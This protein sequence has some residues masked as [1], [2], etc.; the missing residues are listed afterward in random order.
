MFPFYIFII[1][2]ILVVI[3]AFSNAFAEAHPEQM[4]ADLREGKRIYSVSCILCHG[5]KGK[6]DGPASIFIGPYSHPRPNDFT[7]GSFKYRTTDSGDL[8]TLSDLKRTIRYG[9]PGYMPSF[10][11]LEEDG[12]RQVALYV[13]NTFIED[14]LLLEEFPELV[15]MLDPGAGENDSEINNMTQSIS[16][17]LDEEIKV[18]KTDIYEEIDSR[19]SGTEQA[20]SLTDHEVIAMLNSLSEGETRATHLSYRSTDI[21]KINKNLVSLLKRI[22]SSVTANA[23]Q[24]SIFKQ[25]KSRPSQTRPSLKASISR[26]KGIFQEM[27]CTACHGLN[28]KGAKTNMKDERGLP[29]MAADLSQP[30]SF[31]NGN[32]REDI[33][34]TVMTGLNGTPMPSFIDLFIGQVDSAWD[35]IEYV[36]S[37]R[38]DSLASFLP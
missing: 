32:T 20:L 38:E 36:Y 10:K 8:P 24:I 14:E 28:G 26:G 29:V 6:G 4:E 3:L 5:G 22:N 25:V 27:Q 37:L 9:I 34:R 30:S 15:Q 18:K 35:L 23:K 7:V 19:T 21:T 31:G 1:G 33:F 17:P 2:N 13:A 11:H 16:P 12:I